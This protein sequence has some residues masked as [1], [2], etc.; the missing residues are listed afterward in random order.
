MGRGD[1]SATHAAF[2]ALVSLSSV[3]QSST[4]PDIGVGQSP[5][6]PLLE[7]LVLD[8]LVSAVLAALDAVAPPDPFAVW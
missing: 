4:A 6:A 1:R 5:P 3:Q 8:A 7:A 2:P